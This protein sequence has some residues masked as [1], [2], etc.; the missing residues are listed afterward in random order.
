MAGAGS[1]RA[2]GTT[3]ANRIASLPDV[4]TFREAGLNL[5]IYS[6]TGYLAPAKTSDEIVSKLAAAMQAACGDPKV[7]EAFPAHELIG[8]GP[9][10]FGAFLKD[11]IGR[12]AELLK[13]IRS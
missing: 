9:T 8:A 13:D 2:L 6:W 11:E 12:V 3:S 4:P 7:R 1:V 10:E 5:E